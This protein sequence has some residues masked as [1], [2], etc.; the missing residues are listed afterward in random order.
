MFAWFFGEGFYWDKKIIKQDLL[1]KSK[2]KMFLV[3]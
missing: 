3:E 1:K 2:P